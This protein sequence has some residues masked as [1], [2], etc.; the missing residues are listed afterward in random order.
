MVTYFDFPA[1]TETQKMDPKWCQK[2]V[3]TGDAARARKGLQ[4]TEKNNPAASKMDARWDHKLRKSVSAPKYVMC[5]WHSKNCGQLHIPLPGIP[6]NTARKIPRN[7][8]P[9]SSR[10]KT[11]KII[12]IWKMYRKPCHLEVQ[13]DVNLS[14]FFI[15]FSRKWAKV[16][17]GCPSGAQGYHN[18][19]PRSLQTHKKPPKC[20]PRVTKWTPGCHNGAPRMT[21]RSPKVTQSAKKTSQGLPKCY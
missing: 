13:L 20:S 12:K 16:P 21:K 14:S 6:E 10:H 17:Q 9:P 18:G 3:A 1:L 8:C 2:C 4:K 5:V 15:P 11:L 7:R 19:A